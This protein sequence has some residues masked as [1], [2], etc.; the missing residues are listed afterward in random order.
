MNTIDQ[1]KKQREVS[2]ELKE[3]VKV[4]GKINREILKALEEK[5]KTIPQISEETKL[6]Q[7]LVTYHLMTLLKYGKIEAGEIDDLDEY[8]YYNLKK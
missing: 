6:E 3:R 5:G 4:I 8:Y 7:H 2:E 1:I